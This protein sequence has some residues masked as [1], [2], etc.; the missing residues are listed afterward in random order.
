MP[1]AAF[2]VVGLVQLV[3]AG[4]MPRRTEVGVL[5]AARWRAFGR[6]LKERWSKGEVVSR[7]DRF[8][9][10]LPY[11]IALGA[12]RE[13]VRRFAEAGAPA[14]DWYTWDTPPARYHGPPRDRPAGDAD[15]ASPTDALGDAAAG[16]RG[17]LSGLQQLS[18]GGALGLQ[19]LS[20]GLVEML[21]SASQTLSTGGSGGWSGGGGGSSGGGGGGG[22][23]GGFD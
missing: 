12:D 5:A 10:Y 13:W 6:Y 1:F 21:N 15:L 11:A 7:A 14:P 16:E 9:P 2:G 3:A 18:D 19:R 20:D 17:G 23:S 8:E 4:R 22:G